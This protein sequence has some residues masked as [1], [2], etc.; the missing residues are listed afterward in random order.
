LES[1]FAALVVT[2]AIESPITGTL[3]GMRNGLAI[4]LL[5]AVAMLSLAGNASAASSHTT[6]VL[7]RH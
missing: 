4:A 1:G 6:V 7:R 3:A 5:G 2:Q